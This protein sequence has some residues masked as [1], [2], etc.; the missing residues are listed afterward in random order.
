[1]KRLVAAPFLLLHFAPRSPALALALASGRP[2]RGGSANPSTE[3]VRKLKQARDAKEVFGFLDDF[4]EDINSFV[5]ATAMGKLRRFGKS[6][7]ALHVFQRSKARGIALNV[8]VYNA[9]ISAS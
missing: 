2:R 1:M 8:V 7:E 3:L 9:A 4:Y 5:I 6:R